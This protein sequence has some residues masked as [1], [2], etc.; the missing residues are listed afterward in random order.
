MSKEFHLTF[1]NRYHNKVTRLV[2]LKQLIVGNL[3]HCFSLVL[4]QNICM[5]RNENIK[6]L[7]YSNRSRQILPHPLYDA[8]TLLGKY[9]SSNRVSSRRSIVGRPSYHLGKIKC[10]RVRSLPTRSSHQLLLQLLE[11]QPLP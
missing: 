11:L 3:I 8:W 2:L 7:L 5:R 6:L 4:R 10:D 9:R 1:L